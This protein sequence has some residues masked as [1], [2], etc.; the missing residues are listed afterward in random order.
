MVRQ[1]PASKGVIAKILFPKGLWVKCE[2]PA[3]AGVFL[4]PYFNC[5]ELRVTNFHFWRIYFW[6]GRCLIPLDL[7]AYFGV[8]EGRLGLDMR[9]L[10]CFCGET[11]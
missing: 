11:L 1:N 10:G 3:V 9:V 6:V 8:D 7:R 2:T 5:I 4:S